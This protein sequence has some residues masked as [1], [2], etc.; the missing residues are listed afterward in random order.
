MVACVCMLDMWLFCLCVEHVMLCVCVKHV[1]CCVCQECPCLV[2]TELLTSIQSVS[3]TPIS[4]LLLYNVSEGEELLPGST[5][6]HDCSS[7]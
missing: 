3:V 5:L 7:W 4:S 6:Q 1:M 2:D